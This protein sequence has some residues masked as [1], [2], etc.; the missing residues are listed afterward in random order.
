ME[1]VVVANSLLWLN[2]RVKNLIVSEVMAPSQRPA[3]H[4]ANTR[5]LSLVVSIL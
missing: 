3:G 2:E 5:A 4:L 1:I